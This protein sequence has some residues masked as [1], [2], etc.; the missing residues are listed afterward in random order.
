MSKLTDILP[1]KAEELV[2]EPLFY[3]DINLQVGNNT[4]LHRRWIEKGV[5]RI[6]HLSHEHGAFLCLEEFDMKYGLNT[7]FVTYNGCVQAS[8]KYIKGLG[9]A[10]QSNKSLNMRN[11]L[12]MIGKVQKGT[13][14]YYDILFENKS[15]P[16][17]CIKW[18][19]VLPNNI[20]WLTTFY[21]KYKN[22]R[23]K[24]EMF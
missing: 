10:V 14:S 11:S 6:S 15:K 4:M 21:K 18:N 8:K 12:S 22:I 19:K 9:I 16:K 24:T 13:K 3:T 17:C 1:E 20:N 5:Y 23:S 7:D 2:T